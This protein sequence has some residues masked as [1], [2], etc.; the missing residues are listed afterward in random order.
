MLMIMMMIMIIVMII[1][2]MIMFSQLHGQ[3]AEKRKT[4]KQNGARTIMQLGNVHYCQNHASHMPICMYI[5]I[6]IYDILYMLYAVSFDTVV[7]LVHA[8][9]THCMSEFSKMVSIYIPPFG[10]DITLYITILQP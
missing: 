9:I 10:H 8:P 4:I 5:N 3:Y 2:M 7:S 6:Y 1:M